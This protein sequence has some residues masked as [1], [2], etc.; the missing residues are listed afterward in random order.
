MPRW[1]SVLCIGILLV[2]PACSGPGSH[3][4]SRGTTTTTISGP[5]VED[6]ET[7]AC[8]GGKLETCL[9]L[10]HEL[11]SPEADLSLRAKLAREFAPGCERS[12][13]EDC[14]RAALFAADPDAMLELMQR[15]CTGN[16]GLACRM[17]GETLGKHATS[18]ELLAQSVQFLTQGCELNDAP[19]CVALGRTYD[20]GGPGLPRDAAQA[21]TFFGK[22]CQQLHDQVA[23]RAAAQ[24]GCREGR[25]EDCAPPNA[26]RVAH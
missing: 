7:K 15:A 13:P 25:L 20:E 26:P 3:S 18:A 23:C 16:M 10:A 8:V 19:S 12:V 21:A 14:F 1:S 24:L 22:G 5:H 11:E 6:P 17:L 2:V 9:V 4:S